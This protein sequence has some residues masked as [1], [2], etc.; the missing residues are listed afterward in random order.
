MKTTG[1]ILEVMSAERPYATSRPVAV[2]E[3][4][5]DGPGP[6]EVLIR[7]EAAGVCHSDLSVVS[8]VRPRPLPMLLGHEAAGIVQERGSLVDN[9]DVGDR[10]IMTFLPRCG[11]CAAC[12]SDGKI[13][14]SAGSAANGEGRLLDGERRLQDENGSI[15]HHLGVSGFA[16][17]AVVD[18]RS[19]VKVGPDVPA[20][21]A[22]LMGCAVLTGGGAVKNAGRLR[23][24]ETLVV[25]GLG[26]VG[27]AAVL[28]GLAYDDVTV[29]G[30][31]AAAHKLETALALGA[32]QAL[33]PQEALDA[34]IRGD[35]VVEAVGRVQAL[36][37]AIELTA[38]GGRTVTVGLP[39]PSEFA[40]ISPV[41]LVAEGRSIIGS[42][43]GNCVPD[44]D[45]AFFIDMWRAGRLPVERLISSR[46]ALSQI[47]E[48]FDCLERGDALRQIIEFPNDAVASARSAG[49]GNE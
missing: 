4:E 40:T 31:D 7:V 48:A 23:E 19:V 30:V 42:Y 5:L 3:V 18:Y 11:E 10:V 49:S 6:H 1:A 24:G 38:I 16:T 32:H 2:R 22:A 45:L 29:I 26:G 46:L 8:G 47:N 37:S 34:G 25:V 12:A 17:Y 21:V 15:H 36:E 13:P 43:L 20:D 27:M 39:A 44:R 33:T 41:R 35:L 28:V 14:C 9:L